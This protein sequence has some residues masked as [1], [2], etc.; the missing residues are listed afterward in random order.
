MLEI[1]PKKRSF[2]ILDEISK[3]IFIFFGLKL[4]YVPS[5]IKIGKNQFFLFQDLINFGIWRNFDPKHT[6]DPI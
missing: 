2:A 6:K 4:S 1:Y 3:A 5:F